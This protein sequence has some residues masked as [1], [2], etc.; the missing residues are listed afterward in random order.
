MRG[1]SL[2]ASRQDY[3]PAHSAHHSQYSYIHCHPPP[4]QTLQQSSPVRLP[5]QCAVQCGTHQSLGRAGRRKT[6]HLLM[7]CRLSTLG[8]QR[9]LSETPDRWAAA[10]SFSGLSSQPVWSLA[11]YIRR[12]APLFPQSVP[13]SDRRAACQ[14]IS[15]SAVGT[16]VAYRW[17]GA[18]GSRTAVGVA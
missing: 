10:G 12:E 6:R 7:R 18:L 2:R 3:C 15:S 14:A 4:C 11:W 17:R 9:R 8:H 16:A 1:R 5:V 13:W